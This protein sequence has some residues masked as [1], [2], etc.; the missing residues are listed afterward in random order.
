[1]KNLKR[2]ERRSKQRSKLLRRAK[3]WVETCYNLRKNR[4]KIINEI[5]EG[6]GFY[7]L[8]TTLNPCNCYMCSGYEKYKRVEQKKK[9][10]W[11]INLEV[12]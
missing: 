3:I 1:M 5:M 6:K 2:S 12:N 11:E 8:R 9:D 4:T 10:L 7:F